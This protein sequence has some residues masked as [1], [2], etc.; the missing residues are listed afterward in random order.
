MDTLLLVDG[1]NLLFQMFYGMPARIVNSQ[2]RAI[3]G[4]LGFVGALLKIIKMVSPT[5]IAVLFDGES[6]NPRYSLDSDYKANRPDYSETTEEE[7]PFSQLPDIFSALKFLRIPFAET[8]ACETD[9]WVSG[10]AHTYGKSC[11]IVISSFDSDYFQLVSENVSVLRY[12][13]E[14]T[15]ICTPLFVQDKFGVKPCQYADFKCLVGDTSDNI[16][17]ASKVGPKTAKELISQ[18][19]SL[20]NILKNCDEISK[21]AIKASII[22]GR[23]RLRL[24][25]QLIKLLDYRPLPFEI[26]ELKYTYQGETTTEVLT[27]IGIK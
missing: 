17:G 1:S 13:G 23:E 12:R 19:K 7:T 2:G 18:F 16:K 24:N 11:K 10:Y 8:T 9:D 15:Q 20:E 6:T 3:H 25:Y 4:T 14:K 26:S 5:H 22:E 27:A 21:P